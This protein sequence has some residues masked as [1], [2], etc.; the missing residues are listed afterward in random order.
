MF[1]STVVKSKK[2]HQAKMVEDKDL[3]EPDT[4]KETQFN[5]VSK[6]LGDIEA[7]NPE[8]DHLNDHL[9]G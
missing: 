8:P 7:L 5:S 4:M 9:G 6:E 3:V 1:I 2:K